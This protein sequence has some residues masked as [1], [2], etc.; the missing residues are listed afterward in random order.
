VAEDRLVAGCLIPPEEVLQSEE[1]F[2]ED[3]NNKLLG[4]EEIGDSKGEFDLTGFGKDDLNSLSQDIKDYQQSKIDHQQ[5]IKDQPDKK[6][7]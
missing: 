7:V 3:M 1:S 4:G 2:N 5:W 6:N